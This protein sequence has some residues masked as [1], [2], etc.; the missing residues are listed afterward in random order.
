MPRNLK[1]PAGLKA[2][3]ISR[4]PTTNTAE[5]NMYGEVVAVQPTDWWGDPIPGD[6]VILQDFL[7]GT[8]ICYITAAFSGNQQFLAQAVIPLQK[9]HLLST[10]CRSDGRK[11]TRRAAA[12]D[13]TIKFHH[14]STCFS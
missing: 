1:N 7:A 14:F 12:N 3:A 5:I 8:V 13:N 9:Q 11:H 6:Y 4:D 10:L 2:Y